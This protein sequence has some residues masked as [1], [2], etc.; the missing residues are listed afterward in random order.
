MTVILNEAA[1]TR[2]FEAPEGPVAR[3]V[4][5]TAEAV[6][7][8]AQIQFDDY[9]HFVLPPE[10]DIDFTMQGSTATIGYVGGEGKSKTKRLAAAEADG[11][12]TNPPLT[13]ALDKI[14]SGSGL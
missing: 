2:L 9:F 12:L 1:I 7:A 5:R 4:E 14:R 13:Q 11:N 3:F 10:R 8:L 6:V